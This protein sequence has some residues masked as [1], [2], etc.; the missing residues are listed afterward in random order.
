MKRDARAYLLEIREN[1]DLILKFVSNVDLSAYKADE[2][3][4]SAVE[5]RFIVIG[6]IL[7][8]L[9]QAD[10][11]LVGNFPDSARIVSFRNILVHGYESISDELVW[12]VINEHLPSLRTRCDE[13]LAG[14]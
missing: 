1:C 3:R 10:F 6:E 14:E 5:R 11:N 8:R 7:S 2:L 12:E 9:K 4:K 13:L